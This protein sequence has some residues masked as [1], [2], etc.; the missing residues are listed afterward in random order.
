LKKKEPTAWF[1]ACKL[2]QFK[3]PEVDSKEFGLFEWGGW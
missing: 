1:G 3:K 2:N